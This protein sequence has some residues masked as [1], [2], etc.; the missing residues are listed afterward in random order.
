MERA[1]RDG[2]TDPK[3]IRRNVENIVYDLQTTY[4]ELGETAREVNE[5]IAK[6]N[7]AMEQA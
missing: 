7:F 4:K 6:I 1:V 2:W 3:G 5:N